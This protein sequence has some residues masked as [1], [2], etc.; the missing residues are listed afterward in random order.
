MLGLSH[1]PDHVASQTTARSPGFTLIELLVVISIIALLIGILLPA[2]GKARESATVLKS[3]SGIR[4]LMI[5]Y[6][7]YMSDFK[8]NV[9]PG[10]PY[11]GATPGPAGF[12]SGIVGGT[13]VTPGSPTSQWT[14]DYRGQTMTLSADHAARYPFRILPYVSNAIEITH[15]H[16]LTKPQ[17]EDVVYPPSTTFA[18]YPGP[19]TINPMYGLNSLY[20]GGHGAHNGTTYGTSNFGGYR[21]G[22]PVRNQHAVFRS[23]EVRRPS[24]LIVFADSKHTTG[25]PYGS[26]APVRGDYTNTLRDGYFYVRP[27]RF[28][29]M[30]TAGTDYQATINFWT[31]GANFSAEPQAG[32]PGGMPSPW[33]GEKV[34]TSY[35]DGHAN[36]M[37]IEDL[38]DMRLWSN[39]AQ[40]PN[41]AN[42]LDDDLQN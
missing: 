34:V 37:S 40:G 21:D 42:P 9:L 5:G 36:S 8:Q 39:N 14:I 41:D 19:L 23:D 6:H 11:I 12:Y 16:R 4:Q 2:L 24:N 7:G 1:K 22:K 26:M 13:Q 15:G 18:S 35:F 28:A 20:I 17:P 38:N 27:P 31:P 25:A 10:Y 29:I 30:N 33:F 32:V 3:Q